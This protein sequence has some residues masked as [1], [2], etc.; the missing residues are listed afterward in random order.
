M[1]VCV[2]VHVHVCMC[3]HNY[4]CVCAHLCVT[5]K[6]EKCC[7]DVTTA[8][9]SPVTQ[10]TVGSATVLAL[11]KKVKQLQGKVRRQIRRAEKKKKKPPKLISLPMRKKLA[12][13]HLSHLFSG[14]A[15]QFWTTQIN[16]AKT[17]SKGH[18]WSDSD[19]SFA[20]SLLHA[21][22][23]AYQFIKKYLYLPDEKTLR[24][25]VQ[26]NK[27]SVVDVQVDLWPCSFACLY[28]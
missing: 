14:M 11:Q 18:R 12:I 28:F 15:F 19:K 22:P 10:T 25:T 9:A 3:A 6:A 8:A 27:N 23:K 26:K 5:D 4:V 2:C 20:L 21:S 17:D 7:L 1:C 13:K 16:L 24:R